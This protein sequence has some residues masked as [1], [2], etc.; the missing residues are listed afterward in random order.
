MNRFNK[1]NLSGI[2]AMTAMLLLT[3]EMM[4]VKMIFYSIAETN[5]I[6]LF[7]VPLLQETRERCSKMNRRKFRRF[8]LRIPSCFRKSNRVGEQ[9]PLL[10]TQHKFLR[11]INPV[12]IMKPSG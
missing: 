1:G 10:W 4:K 2:S 6:S 3:L 12:A 11:Q 7:F 9:H 5:T 8:G